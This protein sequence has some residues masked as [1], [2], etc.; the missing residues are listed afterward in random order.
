MKRIENYTCGSLQFKCV[1]KDFLKCKM[2]KTV[3]GNEICLMLLRL[4]FLLPGSSCQGLGL[5]GHPLNFICANLVA[6][7]S[8]PLLLMGKFIAETQASPHPLSETLCKCSPTLSLPRDC[9]KLPIPS[10]SCLGKC[11]VPSPALSLPPLDSLTSI[12]HAG[13]EVQKALYFF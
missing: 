12:L 13:L 10:H 8:G 1:E 2:H 3:R 4:S 11:P 9:E 5:Q 7:Q 6:L